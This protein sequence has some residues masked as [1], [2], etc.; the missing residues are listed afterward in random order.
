MLDFA[1]WNRHRK[2]SPHVFSYVPDVFFCF[3]ATSLWTRSL[4]VLHADESVAF[5][6][7][8]NA[9]PFNEFGDKMV[10][11]LA[12]DP[13]SKLSLGSLERAD[14]RLGDTRPSFGR[15]ILIWGRGAFCAF[16]ACA[17]CR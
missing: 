17:T 12:G 9:Y 3:S 8:Q 11:T 10:R 16:L 15:S 2:K 13:V 7:I 5:C 1:S 6:Q 14:K 4:G